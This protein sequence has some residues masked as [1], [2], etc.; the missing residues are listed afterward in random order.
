MTYV[1]SAP[2]TVHFPHSS[3]RPNNGAQQVQLMNILIPITSH[4]RLG[5][6]GRPTGYWLEELAAPYY[7]F[8][9][10]GA[11]VT[12]ATPKGG[13]APV[14][15]KSESPGSASEHTRRFVADANAIAQV[16]DTALIADQDAN[17]F[18]A[19][20]FPGGHGPL[21]DLAIDPCVK[22][23]VEAF[24]RAKKPIGAV[25]HGPAALVGAQTADGKSILAGRTVTAFSDSEEQAAGLTEVVPFSLQQRLTALGG[26]YRCGGN[27][28]PFVRVD[29]HL[30][31]GQ[32]PASSM[33]TAKAVLTLLAAPAG[34]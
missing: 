33:D 21:W 10:A 11:K 32:N 5:D 1:H 29:G 17:E 28:V 31:T 19:L 26:N 27:W 9:A 15:P 4:D 3:Q 14:D 24:Y 6:T 2:I 25:C 20:F 23:L 34:G 7:V 30:V 12:I 18:D 8:V 16:A 22:A 13:H